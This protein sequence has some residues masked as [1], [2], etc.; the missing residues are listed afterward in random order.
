VRNIN[1]D[2]KSYLLNTSNRYQTNQHIIG[3]EQVFRGYVVKVWSRDC[4]DQYFNAKI[5]SN[6]VKFCTSHYI[7]Y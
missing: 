2:L 3:W 5:N 4:N 1:N 7:E 6:M